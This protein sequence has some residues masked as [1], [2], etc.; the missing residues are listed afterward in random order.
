MTQRRKLTPGMR[1][2]HRLIGPGVI[3]QEWGCWIDCGSCLKEK[4]STYCQKCE[5]ETLSIHVS[6]RGTFEIRFKDGIVR[7]IHQDH[8]LF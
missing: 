5:T 4:R 2:E 3:V 6:G 1:V 7:S 8:L